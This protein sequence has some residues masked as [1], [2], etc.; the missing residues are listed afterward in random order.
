[1]AKIRVGCLSQLPR[2]SPKF[3][4]RFVPDDLLIS[5]WENLEPLFTDLIDRKLES[6]EALEQW[7]LN[8]SELTSVI[9]EEFARRRIAL[10]CDTDGRAAE[11]AFLDF[12][13]NISP[14]LASYG[15]S[16]NLKFL[17]CPYTD[18]LD[19]ERYKVD[20]RRRRCAV[21]LFSQDNVP[22]HV[23]ID[24][25]A[26]QY[27]KIF[28]AMTVNFKG[29]EHTLP[30]MLMYFQDKDRDLRQDAWMITSDR[31]LREAD[32][33][34]ELFDR[35]LKLRH[36]IARNT[37]FPDFR[38]Y[39]FCAENRFDYTPEDCIRLHDSIQ[40]HA[41]PIAAA[42]VEERQRDLGVD[43]VRPWDMY[44]DRYGRTRLRPFETA[45]QLANGC[46]EMLGKV[47][48]EIGDSVQIMIDLG[49]LDLENR[50]GKTAFS[51]HLNL[52]EVRLPYI[53]MC[54]IG[55]NPDIFT[56]LHECGHAFHQFASREEPLVAYRSV[57]NEFAEV[58]A[59]TMELLSAEH[60]EVFYKPV[61]AAR[62][63]R[64]HF[65]DTIGVFPEVGIIDAFQHWIYTHPDHTAE[66][67]SDYWV[68]LLERFY[69]G[70]DW[71]GLEAISR[72]Y[73]HTIPHIFLRP[74]YFIEYAIAQLGALN[75]W[76]ESR[77]HK[78][79][80]IQAF[81]SA[82]RLGGSKPLPELFKAAE[83][84]FDFSERT[85]RPLMIGVFEEVKRQGRLEIR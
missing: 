33:L 56:L 24:R 2:T 21:R 55:L 27:Q 19:Q 66:K 60:L 62:A 20:I 59:M 34:N 47:D 36:K 37:G 42:M 52:P 63:R 45:D 69:N 5:S 85:I 4:R 30:E 40:K 25:L 10:A 49:L 7:L 78:A 38:S 54:A 50:K 12:V 82:L 83:I 15:H 76:R 79:A 32:R 58:A 68:S 81:K 29:K 61:D 48:K 18:E 75:I 70:V 67:R 13:E 9:G 73:W 1:M 3:P 46:R 23:E 64:R 6:K 65:E 71:S 53:F 41:L 72:N 74:F 16:I 14:R 84:E 43:S 28:G 51:Y 39:I 17:E 22:L 80:A 35:L 44:C 26:Q 31:R 8:D 57:P 77:R 11:K